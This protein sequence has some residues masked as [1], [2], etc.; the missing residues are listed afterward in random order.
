[1]FDDLKLM[2]GFWCGLDEDIIFLMSRGYP[3]LSLVEYINF[4]LWV[5]ESSLGNA[6][7]KN[8]TTVQ[9]H[10]TSIVMSPIP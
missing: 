5:D 1:M 4:T 9:P 3:C 2:E 6:E 7:E 8:S 10:P